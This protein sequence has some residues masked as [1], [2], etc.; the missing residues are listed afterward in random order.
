MM[1]F[2][3]VWQERYCNLEEGIMAHKHNTCDGCSKVQQQQQQQR[4]YNEM[5]SQLMPSGQCGRD[6]GWT[7]SL[8]PETQN[9]SLLRWIDVRV[10]EAAMLG[11]DMMRRRRANESKGHK[12][13]VGL[14][15]R[16]LLCCSRIEG[17]RNGIHALAITPVV[18]RMQMTHVI[19]LLDSYVGHVVATVLGKSPTTC[20]QGHYSWSV[21][22]PALTHHMSLAVRGYCSLVGCCAY[23]DTSP[24]ASCQESRGTGLAR[25]LCC[26]ARYQGG[27]L[28]DRR[29]TRGYPEVCFVLS[30][31]RGFG[32]LLATV[33]MHPPAG[34]TFFFCFG[35]CHHRCFFFISCLLCG[36]EVKR[37]TVIEKKMKDLMMPSVAG[38]ILSCACQELVMVLHD[39]PMKKNRWSNAWESCIELLENLIPA[40][41]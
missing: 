32:D 38:I 11:E 37:A 36:I 33:C 22:V 8:A 41:A 39:E 16:E 26:V 9:S 28:A 19:L 4:S 12:L 1:S 13:G 10:S 3:G 24:V 25:G 15:K 30:K 7:H 2:R 6:N 31:T 34:R 21:A 14:Q 18:R 27:Q 23:P 20:C 29:T 35:S 17:R 40:Y 5:V